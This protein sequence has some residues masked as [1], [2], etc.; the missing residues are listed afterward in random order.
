MAFSV[1]DIIAE[2]GVEKILQRL[3]NPERVSRQQDL[4]DFGKLFN[5]TP[6]QMKA[7]AREVFQKAQAKKLEMIEAAVAENVAK[8]KELHN[9]V[10]ALAPQVIEEKVRKAVLEE[11]KNRERALGIHSVA[12]VE[13]SLAAVQRHIFDDMMV[14]KEG[15][16]TQD[17]WVTDAKFANRPNVSFPREPV[18]DQKIV[19]WGF[20]DMMALQANKNADLNTVDGITA[21]L[22]QKN[23]VARR[24]FR[25]DFGNFLNRSNQGLQQL[26]EKVFPLLQQK[27]AG[28]A[29]AEAAR[30]S[31]EIKNTA[32]GTF[33]GNF[34]NRLKTSVT[35]LEP[36]APE[37]RAKLREQAMTAAGVLLDS[38][39]KFVGREK[40]VFDR[41]VEAR[42]DEEVAKRLEAS[43]LTSPQAIYQAFV[44]LRATAFDNN[45]VKTAGGGFTKQ[46]LLLNPDGASN[47]TAVATN[48][49]PGT[50]PV[51]AN[52]KKLSIEAMINDGMKKNSMAWGMTARKPIH[53]IGGDR[54][55]DVA[56]GTIDHWAQNDTRSTVVIGDKRYDLSKAADVTRLRTDAAK[57]YQGF[58]GG[59]VVNTAEL[60]AAERRAATPI[61]AAT[62][63]PNATAAATP[64]QIAPAQARPSGN[65]IIPSAT[66]AP[67]PQRQQT[68]PRANDFRANGIPAMVR[69]PL[70]PIAQTARAASERNREITNRSLDQ[71]RQQ[72]QEQ[73]GTVT[74]PGAGV[75]RPAP[76]T[77]RPG[78]VASDFLQNGVRL[79][80]NRPAAGVAQSN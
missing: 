9:V 26:S 80:A 77:R 67:A 69:P 45:Y 32:V 65:S 59:Q 54:S 48:T 37:E 22:N 49:A 20:N 15:R 25:M 55:A 58:V 10:A 66:A 53:M 7:F 28:I 12:A 5:K 17:G 57:N 51:P 33:F 38:A 50:G 29:E 60:V 61:V 79:P 76:V 75:P 73:V 52:V 3:N 63:P 64:A 43:K 42:R 78:D 68:Q 4:L 2:D 18:T 16:F 31:Q 47:A 70:D 72:F 44:N 14:V 6:P 71:T 62:P 24:D 34:W 36:P 13:K 30:Q 46:G 39:E 19:D 8:Q 40:S 23:D 27:I 1:D 56:S 11:A 74:T 35:T 21:R 41:T